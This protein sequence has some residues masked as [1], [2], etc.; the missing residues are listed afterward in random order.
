MMDTGFIVVMMIV[1]IITKTL[2]VEFLTTTSRFVVKKHILY[3]SM[4]KITDQR[5]VLY[6]LSKVNF[7]SKCLHLFA[8]NCFFNICD[9]RRQSSQ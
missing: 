6:N 5:W 1:I 9:L 8:V 7:A 3:D 2:L 4:R